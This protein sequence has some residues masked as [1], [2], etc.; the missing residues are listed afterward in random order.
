[1]EREGDQEDGETGCHLDA[2]PLYLTA[3]ESKVDITGCTKYGD[4]RG[5]G[6]K[7]AEQGV[8]WVLGRYT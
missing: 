1:M 4:G 7:T 3:T 2:G 8:A 5:L 6:S